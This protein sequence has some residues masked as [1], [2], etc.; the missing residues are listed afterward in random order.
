MDKKIENKILKFVDTL[1]AVYRKEMV[2][3]TLYVAL[4]YDSACDLVHESIRD[5]YKKEINPAGGVNMYAVGDEFCFDF[6]PADSENE[7]EKGVW[8]EFAEEG[9]G[10]TDKE[11]SDVDTLIELE[12]EMKVGK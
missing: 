5:F 4:D 1:K 3:G 9:L 6:V 10:L 7:K 11:L 8:S 12:N 2:H